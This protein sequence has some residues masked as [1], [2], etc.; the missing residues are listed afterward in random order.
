[1]S[2]YSGITQQL[3]DFVARQSFWSAE[4]FSQPTNKTVQKFLKSLIQNEPTLLRL[5]QSGTGEEI[6]EFYEALKENAIVMSLPMMHGLLAEMYASE[7]LQETISQDAVKWFRKMGWKFPEFEFEK[8]E[9]AAP[10]TMSNQ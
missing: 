5:V 3:T 10:E 4:T 9:L 1:M 7:Q 6:A 8:I 2:K